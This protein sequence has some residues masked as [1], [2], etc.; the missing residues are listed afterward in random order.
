MKRESTKSPLR[1]IAV[2]V[3][4]PEPN[5]FAWALAEADK[6]ASNW[7]Q[8]ASADEW[9]GSYKE[10]MAA[11]LLVLQQMIDDLDIGPRDEPPAA[12][13]KP[14]GSPFGFGFGTNLT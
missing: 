13:K 2:Y 11:G 4:E 12:A 7:A 1:R 10:A 6:G 9:V 5:W 8:I 3:N 14:K